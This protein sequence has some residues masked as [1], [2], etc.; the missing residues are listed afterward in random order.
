MDPHLVLVD[1][2]ALLTDGLLRMGEHLPEPLYR[3]S[4][5]EYV[6]TVGAIAPVPVGASGP[7]S[8]DG[9][10]GPARTEDAR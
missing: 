4:F 5:A 10:D 6:E 1:V 2:P 7:T 8:A 3:R 9:A